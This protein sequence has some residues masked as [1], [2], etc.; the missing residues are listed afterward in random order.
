M[1]VRFRAEMAG[2]AIKRQAR[3]VNPSVFFPVE[4]LLVHYSASKFQTTLVPLPEYSSLCLMVDEAQRQGKDSLH[5]GKVRSP[6]SEAS[7]RL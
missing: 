7:N 2:L 5:L 3:I 1:Q 6:R 4:L